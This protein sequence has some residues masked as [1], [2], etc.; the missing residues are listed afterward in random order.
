LRG[1]SLPCA[2]GFLLL[3][4]AAIAAPAKTLEVA[5]TTLELADGQPGLLYVA[6]HST[7]PVTVQIDIYD[8][9]QPGNDDHLVLSD[10][11]FVSPPLTTIAPGERQIVRVLAEPGLRAQ[12]TGYRL[13]VSEL[14]DATQKAGGV[15]VLLQ[16]SIPAFV[17]GTKNAGALDWTATA[18]DSAVE[19]VA[20]NGGNRAVKLAGLHAS[21]REGRSA[22]IAADAVTYILPGSA[23]AWDIAT[24]DFAQASQLHIE[25]TDERAHAPVTA[26]I[27]VTR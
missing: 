3:S 5:P 20:H 17:G 1:W 21:S 2:A 26:D 13:R 18:K 25:A 27:I 15:Q 9:Q 19:L 6:N 23:H 22:N 16:F 11:A 7:S 14:P 12:E 24:R 8:W 4:S 10:T